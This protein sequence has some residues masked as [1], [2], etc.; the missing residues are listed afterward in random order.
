MNVVI[1]GNEVI[2]SKA[3]EKVKSNIPVSG[4]SGNLQS[5]QLVQATSYDYI[6]LVMLASS[7]YLVS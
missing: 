1:L 2:M 3:I 6:Q 7:L 4:E 5:L